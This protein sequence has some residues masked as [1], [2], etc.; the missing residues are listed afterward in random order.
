MGW[1]S[2]NGKWGL[3][4]VD[5]ELATAWSSPYHWSAQQSRSMS[6]D[7]CGVCCP[8]V[9][10]QPTVYSWYSMPTIRHGCAPALDSIYSW[11]GHMRPASRCK[12]SAMID[13]LMHLMSKKNATKV[14]ASQSRD[15][16]T[17]PRLLTAKVGRLLAL[18]LF[19]SKNRLWS[20]L[21]TLCL[22]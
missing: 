9:Q 10:H 13:P 5:Q 7:R 8:T 21:L 17:Q 3:E 20:N 19:H 18:F 4:S 15:T 11:D 6:C 22:N 2:S 16:Y 12:N 14:V 1:L